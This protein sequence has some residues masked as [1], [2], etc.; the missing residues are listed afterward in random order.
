M[1]THFWVTTR[2]FKSIAIGYAISIDKIFYKNSLIALGAICV[3]NKLL[4]FAIGLILMGLISFNE[5]A[6]KYQKIY[7]NFFDIFNV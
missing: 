3:L 5:A 1:L 7:K 6:S 2:G 4:T